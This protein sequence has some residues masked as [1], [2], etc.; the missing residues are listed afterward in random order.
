MAS[1]IFLFWG[2]GSPPCWKPLIVLEEKG[3]TYGQ[4]LISFSEKEHK[5]ED[6]M[7]LNPRGQVP[8]F[9]DGDTIV[10]ES[11][12]ICDYL[13]YKYK[14]QGCCLMPEDPEVR[15][16]VLQRV[17]ETQNLNK[18]LI[19]G[20]VYY[21][22]RTKEDA[23]DEKYLNSKKKEATEELLRWEGY[24]E[25]EGP[26]SYIVGKDFSMADV[27]VFPI[28]AFGVRGKLDLAPFPNLDSY[29]KRLV[30][31]PSIKA[32]WPPHWKESEGKDFFKGV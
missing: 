8:T 6:V 19:E 7:K 5:G 11:G 1:N 15:G 9:R 30:E 22:F 12:A 24:L 26:E 17:H 2:S 16:K 18:A 25:K 4:K 13:E 32:T 3:L 27:F 21:Q 29:Y 14:D 23:I 31:R 28:L 10:N 20:V